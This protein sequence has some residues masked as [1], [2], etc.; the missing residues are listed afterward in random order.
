MNKKI[1]SIGI[2][3]ILLLMCTSADNT[4]EYNTLGTS[5]NDP[6][7]VGHM[8]VEPGDFPFYENWELS[9]EVNPD[10]G[11]ENKTFYV[12]KGEPLTLTAT[13]EVIE[14]A[15]GIVENWKFTL[16]TY[17]WKDNHWDPIKYDLEEKELS[18]PM[19]IEAGLFRICQ[20]S[21]GNI[22][23]HSNAENVLISFKQQGEELVLL[24]SDDG[25]GFDVSQI[26]RI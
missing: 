15:F 21:I 8:S 9:A 4:L 25:N 16:Y 6:T 5:E 23:H 12:K 11:G 13:Y 2:L 18:L 24:I 22:L 14:D 17:K 1:F 10:F 19:E 26:T 7:Y 20:S 3:S